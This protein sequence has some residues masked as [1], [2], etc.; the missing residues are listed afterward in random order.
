MNRNLKYYLLILPWLFSILLGA[1]LPVVS[2][3]TSIV[4][5]EVFPKITSTASLFYKSSDFT[6]HPSP[7]ALASLTPSPSPIPSSSPTFFPSGTPSPMP[8]SLICSPLA[9]ET[10]PELAEIVSDPYNPPPMGRDERHQGVD[11][12]HYSRKGHKSIEGEPVQAVL[13]GRVVSVINN[14]L[15]YGNMVMVET[16]SADLP[17]SLRDAL[18]MAEGESLYLLYAHFGHAPLVKLGD[19]LVCGQVIGDVG[20]TGYNVV[21]PHLHLEGR[22]GPSG[23]IFESMAFYTSSATEQEMENYRRWRMGGEF[24]HFDPMVLFSFKSENSP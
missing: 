13:T 17:A 11:F 20:K 12:S 18:G 15:P 10:I 24:Q 14:R 7:L 4:T 5:P 6:P 21:N 2:T 22:R 1:C 9:W 19:P 16:P 23:A 8:V 3:S